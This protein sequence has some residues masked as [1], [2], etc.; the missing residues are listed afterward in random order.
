VH[1]LVRID[2]N[3]AIGSGHAMRCLA[4]AEAWREQGGHAR[5]AAADLHSGV[6]ERIAGSGFDID[7]LPAAYPDPRDADA[8]CRT[9][10]MISGDGWIVADGYRFD[11]SY[12]AAVRRSGWPLLVIDDYA[13]LPYYDTDVLLNQNIGAERLPYAGP[14]RMTRLLGTRFALLRPEFTTRERQP[15]ETRV[16]ATRLLI[17]M[18]GGD[19][20]N[21][22]ATVLAAVLAM[23]SRPS[24]VR[25]VVGPS[26]PHAL[27]LRRLATKALDVQVVED[28]ADMPGVFDWADLA[29]T[30][31]GSTCWELAYLGVPMI[32]VVT[33][34][35]QRGIA[36]GLAELGAS[37][38]LGWHAEVKRDAVADSVHALQRD[39]PRRMRMAAAGRRLVDGG[40]AARVVAALTASR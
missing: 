23:L 39:A 22:T 17:T 32:T 31:A 30:A 24:H 12:H 13:H 19:P 40:G 3:A 34:D 38:N 35:N 8:L 10:A 16:N 2:A 36:T 27:E 33:A 25:V 7:R 20:D 29:I 6:E 14:A 4:L 18:G 11:G 5:F 37:I 26:N 9:A 15:D 1:L 28:P 21:V